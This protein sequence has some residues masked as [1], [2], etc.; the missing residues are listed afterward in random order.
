MVP[1][2]TTQLSGPTGTKGQKPSQGSY[3]DAP[4]SRDHTGV[5]VEGVE[6]PSQQLH[7]MLAHAAEQGWREPMLL[8][9]VEHPSGAI[10]AGRIIR[11][12][13]EP[14]RTGAIRDRRRRI[15]RGQ[16]PRPGDT[17]RDHRPPR[18]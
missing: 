6:R 7:L 10:V 15:L 16:G 8:E 4:V 5:G 14:G 12:T 9:E 18:E 17:A 13:G 2:P 3:G 11:R 1:Q